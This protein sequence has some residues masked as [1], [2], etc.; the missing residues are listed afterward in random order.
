M[1]TL[2]ASDSLNENCTVI[3]VRVRDVNDMPPVFER[4]D[5][6]IEMAEERRTPFRMN[7]VRM[8]VWVFIFCARRRCS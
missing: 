8:C 7:K 2:V 4:A 5:Y 3:A 6:R 1:L